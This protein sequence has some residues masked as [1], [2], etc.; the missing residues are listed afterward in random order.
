[1]KNNL[2]FF[3]ECYFVREKLREGLG[4]LCIKWAFVCLLNLLFVGKDK[5]GNDNMLK[6]IHY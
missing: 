6:N 2:S 4:L 1:M 5:L 3:Y